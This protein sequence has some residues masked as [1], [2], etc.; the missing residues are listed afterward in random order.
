MVTQ[1]LLFGF[2]NGFIL[3]VFSGRV[4]PWFLLFG[5]FGRSSIFSEIVY[6]WICLGFLFMVLFRVF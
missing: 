1:W 3:V 4:L 5:G 2:T 6:F